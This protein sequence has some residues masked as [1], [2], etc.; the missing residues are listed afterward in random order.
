M[1]LYQWYT[2]PPSVLPATDKPPDM[3]SISLCPLPLK[4][5]PT[6]PSP[7]QAI[8]QHCPQTLNTTTIFLLTFSEQPSLGDFSFSFMASTCFR[9]Y[10]QNHWPNILVIPCILRSQDVIPAVE[11]TQGMLAPVMLCF[12]IWVL[13]TAKACSIHESHMGYL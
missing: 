8:K 3:V 6:H 11:G 13:L 10:V 4:D 2:P 9:L 7:F 12:L 5:G 1:A